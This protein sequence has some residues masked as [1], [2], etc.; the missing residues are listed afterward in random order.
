MDIQFTGRIISAL[1]LQTGTSRRDGK[2]WVKQEFVIEELNQRYPSR[3]CFQVFGNEKLQQFNIHPDEV[4]TVHLGLNSNQAQ[5]GSGRWFNQ[6]DCWK[7]E[8]FGSQPQQGP[9]LPSQVGQPQQQAPLNQPQQGN[10]NQT[11]LPF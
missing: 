2:P 11:D 9:V 1:P 8:R 6:I 10:A 3:C 7:V 4:L 5:D